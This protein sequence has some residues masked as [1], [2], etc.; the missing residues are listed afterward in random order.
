MAETTVDTL[1]VKIQADMA[2]LRRELNSIQKKTEQSTSKMSKSFEKVEKAQQKLK[3]AF[4]ILGTTLATVFT[5]KKIADVSAEFEDLQLTLNTVFKGVE[6][7]QAAMD[8][9]TTFATRTPFDI[10]TLTRS[11]IQLGGAGIKPTEK[12]LTTLGDAASAT[13]NRM[14]TFEALTRIV[15]RAVGGGLGLEELEQLVSAGIPVYKIL[16]D[17]IGVT[18][19]EISD[20]GQSAEGAEKIMN[21]LLTGL[22]KEFGGGMQRAADNLSVSFSNLG[23]SAK[24]LTKEVGD[25]FNDSMTRLNN[26]LSKLLENLTPVAEM[27]GSILDLAIKGVAKT[28]EGLNNLIGGDQGTTKKLDELEEKLGENIKTMDSAKKATKEYSDTMGKLDQQIELAKIRNEEERE[29]HKLLQKTKPIDQEATDNLREK[30]DTLKDLEKTQEKNNQIMQD[31]QK[32]I[33]GNK[34]EQEELNEQIKLFEESLNTVSDVAM[35]EKM[36][37]AIGILKEELRQLDPLMQEITQ[38]F[39]RASTSISQAIADSITEGKNL[40]ESL[41]NITRQVVNQMIAE[42][43]RLKVIGP[44]MSNIFGG[45]GGGGRSGGGFS[46][47]SLFGG[48]MGLGSLAS[49]N[50]LGGIQ[51]AQGFG[52]TASF[53]LGGAFSGRASGGTVAPNR[54]VMVGER[55]PEIFVPNSGGKIVPNHNMKALGGQETVI[56]QNINITTGVSQTV[57]AEVLNMLPAI[58]QETLQAVAD[59][60]LRGGTF[61]AAFTR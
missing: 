6:Q 54:A 26:A 21:A 39:D 11:F 30:F 35:K 57:R 45:M 50:P 3:S 10:E 59:S 61:G 8:F 24:N 20:L 25:E 5:V 42:F 1:L 15:T 49:G 13:V 47:S 23:I 27:F 22:D 29:F 2:G 9:I 48:F 28:L 46:L 4:V 18:R 55:G 52:Q 33:E 14:Q 56:N 17:E 58:K 36:V 7:G 44:L 51:A 31:A 16:N 60:R 40:M 19:Q 12:L 53:M 38:I 43:L 32:I 41:G 37:E 34:T